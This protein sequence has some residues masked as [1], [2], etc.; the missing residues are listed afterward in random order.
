MFSKQPELTYEMYL[1]HECVSSIRHDFVNREMFAI[2]RADANHN[3]IVCNM[4]A[5]IH[6]RL[7]GTNYRLFALD[8]KVSI[9][10]AD[11][12]TYYPDVVVVGDHGD[13]DPF[14]IQKPCLL[15]EVM[16]PCTALL[17]R[18][19]KRFN[20]QKLGSLQEYVLVSQFDMKVELYRRDLQG[21]WLV[22]SLGVGDSLHLQSIDLAIALSDIYEDV[23]L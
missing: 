2:A 3:L 14:V 15:V 7:R 13:I 20:Y 4:V 12:A 16:S 1:D 17:D 21:G 22:E 11:Y 10:A 9:A 6:G 18:R 23:R 8:M 5:G 19:E